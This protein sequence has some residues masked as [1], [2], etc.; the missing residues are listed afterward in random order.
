MT[1]SELPDL[2]IHTISNGDWQR[3]DSNELSLIISQWNL[4]MLQRMWEY[5]PVPD[6]IPAERTEQLNLSLS[7]YLNRYLAGGMKWPS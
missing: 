1:A 7:R 5:C 3:L 6:G 2:P 4:Y